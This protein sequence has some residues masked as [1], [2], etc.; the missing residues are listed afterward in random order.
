MIVTC[1]ECAKKLKVGDDLAGKKVRCPKCKAL[2][3]VPAPEA[4]ADDA[5]PKKAAKPK[6][7][8]IPEEEDGSEKEFSSSVL[9]SEKRKKREE[10]EEESDDENDDIGD[11]NEKRLR[12]PNC[13]STKVLQLPPNP[14]SQRPGFR[15][16]ECNAK[17]RQPGTTGFLIF[18]T[19][20]GGFIS[21]I[22]VGLLIG[23][24]AA[25]RLRGQ[26]T[27]AAVMI[28]F[29]GF[30]AAIWAIRQIFLPVPINAPEQPSRIWLWILLP[31]V[32]IGVL[33]VCV[34]GGL[35]VTLYYIQEGF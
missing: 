34:G 9:K 27:A 19:M 30:S 24:F 16:Q 11:V 22:G 15:C 10:E 29:A 17:M 14:W 26:S 6:K 32:I 4:D 23:A 20:L 28:G 21:L 12:C 35:F 3:A 33:L 31:I 5:T 13:D 7:K 25:D 2:V 8:P 18:A 1:A